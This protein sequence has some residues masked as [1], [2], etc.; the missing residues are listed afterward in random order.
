MDEEE[1]VGKVGIINHDLFLLAAERRSW[2]WDSVCLMASVS[3]SL[4]GKM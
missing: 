1:S 2:S 4:G 3:S